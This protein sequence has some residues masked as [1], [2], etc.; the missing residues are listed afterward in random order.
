MFVLIVALKKMIYLITIPFF[1]RVGKLKLRD[2]ATD[3]GTKAVQVA[4]E[5]YKGPLQKVRLEIIS[6]SGNKYFQ[7]THFTFIYTT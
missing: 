4:W 1:L 3:P 2:F 6:D 5:D 7:S